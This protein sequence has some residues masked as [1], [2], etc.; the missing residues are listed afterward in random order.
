MYSHIAIHES[1]FLRQARLYSQDVDLPRIC[2]TT[3]SSDCLVVGFIITAQEG[4][5]N[6]FF[7]FSN[8]RTI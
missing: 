2:A 1:R 6:T 4:F 8:N 7:G 5:V 3:P